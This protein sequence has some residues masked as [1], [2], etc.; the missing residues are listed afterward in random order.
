MVVRNSCEFPIEFYSLEFDHQYL[1]EEQVRGE[2]WCPMFMLPELH[3]A[4]AFPASCQGDGGIPRAKPG[5]VL[6]SA[7]SAGR[8]WR[9]L[10]GPGCR[11]E[12]TKEKRGLLGSLFM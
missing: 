2:V 3:S 10:G 5:G 9:G 11:E 8:L 12:G 4:P 7:G 6:G 1:A